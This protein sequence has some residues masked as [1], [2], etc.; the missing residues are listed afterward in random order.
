MSIPGNEDREPLFAARLLPRLVQV[1]PEDA[2]RERA[3]RLIEAE[4]RIAHVK[5]SLLAAQAG[6]EDQ[7]ARQEARQEAQDARDA[8]LGRWTRILAWWTAA[9]ALTAAWVVWYAEHMLPR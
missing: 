7:E 9:V 3:D 1:T 6:L 2:A 8:H 4:F 5:R